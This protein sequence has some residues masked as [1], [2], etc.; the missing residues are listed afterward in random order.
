MPS[1]WNRPYNR[2]TLT[3][4]KA[5]AGDTERLDDKARPKGSGSTRFGLSSAKK[6]TKPKGRR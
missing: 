5:A 6:D 4:Q 3:G 2:T 1:S